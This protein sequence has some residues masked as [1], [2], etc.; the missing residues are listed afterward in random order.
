M[1]AIS[2]RFFW[3]TAVAVLSLSVSTARA[4]LTRGLVAHYPFDGNADDVSG[5]ANHGVIVPSDVVGRWIHLVI[6]TSARGTVMYVNGVR[7]ASNE[8][9]VQNTYVV[10]RDLAIGVNVSPAGYAPYIDA[11][12]GYLNGSIDDV[13]IYNRRLGR[14]EI[15]QL[16]SGTP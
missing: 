10:G 8:N 5:N 2:S 14:R 6:L 4:D 9:F 15:R 12:V 7:A 3:W 1:Q 11:N 16:Y 13:R